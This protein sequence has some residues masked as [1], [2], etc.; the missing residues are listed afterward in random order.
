MNKFLFLGFI[1][2]LLFSCE[3]LQDVKQTKKGKAISYEIIEKGEHS[4]V[5]VRKN[6]V[7]S[8][9]EDFHNFLR[10]Y[11]ISKNNIKVNFDKKMLIG[12][13][14]GEQTTGGFAINVQK[15]IEN[16]NKVIIYYNVKNNQIATMVIT[17]PYLLIQITKTNKPI[18]FQLIN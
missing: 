2:F 15:I 10:K 14:L 17:T 18:D 3:C 4:G 6:F 8:S 13:F 5:K 9:K 1:S 11:Q 7:I 12:I 16:D